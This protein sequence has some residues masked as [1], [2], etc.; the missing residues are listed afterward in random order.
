MNLCI[1]LAYFALCNGA[2]LIFDDFESG[3]LDTNKWTTNTT[4]TDSPAIEFQPSRVQFTNRAFLI[5]KNE[6][7][8]AIGCGI[9]V[10]GQWTFGTSQDAL[11]VTTRTNAVHNPA[12]SCTPTDGI[13]ASYFQSIT[14]QPGWLGLGYT[15][16]DNGATG[17]L[18]VDVSDTINFNVTDDGTSAVATVS[19]DASTA[20]DSISFIVGTTS[21]NYVV[22]ANREFSTENKISY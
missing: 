11:T 6:Y 19:K 5:S 22:L 21:G 13:L 8:P 16:T 1:L 18:I 12:F 20:T 17:S 10:E 15:F 14:T 2:T 9:R 7:N 4:C 3:T